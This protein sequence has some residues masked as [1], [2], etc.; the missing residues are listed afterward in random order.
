MEYTLTKAGGKSI[1]EGIAEYFSGRRPLKE[2]EELLEM[3]GTT[4]QKFAAVSFIAGFLLSI[5][6]ITAAFFAKAEIVY[7]TL[8]AFACFPFAFFFNYFLQQYIFELNKRKKELLVPDALLQ[9][10][11][12]PKGTGIEKVLSYLSSQDFGLLGKEFNIAL[13]Q[14]EKGASVKKALQALSK[15]NK[16][17]A[18]ERA[19][20]LL[21]QGYES[22]A[23]MSEIFREAASDLLETNA[24]LM[25]RNAAMIVEK[26]TILF[27]GGLIVPAVLGLITGLISGLNIEAFPLLLGMEENSAERAGML[28]A[29][30]LANKIYIAEYAIIASVFLAAQEGNSKKAIFYASILLP[31]SLLTYF[32]ASGATF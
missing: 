4:W 20:S 17:R 32:F 3:N 19:V 12:F 16:S 11:I 24:I 1:G 5:A 7:I 23:D 28:A 29:V 22:G 10:S 30:L 27:A 18:I 26:Y 21:L 9:A 25:E 6:A 2:F 31:A 8:L 15:R 14:V 13:K